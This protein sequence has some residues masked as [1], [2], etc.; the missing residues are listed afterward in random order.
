MRQTLH[1]DYCERAH[2]VTPQTKQQ[3]GSSQNGSRGRAETKLG[4]GRSFQAL[5]RLKTEDETGRSKR[6]SQ[7]IFRISRRCTAE[8]KQNRTALLK[9][10]SRQDIG[11][12]APHTRALDR[13]RLEPG[14]NVWRVEAA[15]RAAVLVDGAAYFGAL[16]EAMLQARDTIHIVGWDLDSQMR[17]VGATGSAEDGLPETL[18]AFLTALVKRNPRLRVRLLLW[19][20]SVV[21]S[22][23]RELAPIYSLFWKTPPQIDLCLDDVLPIGASHHQKLVVIDDQLAFCGGLDLT[24]RRWDTPEHRTDNPLRTDPRGVRYPPFHDVQMVVDGNA[25]TALGD[26]VRE[27]WARAA[28][29][30]IPPRRL[31]PDH[32]PWPSSV[33]PLMRD[34]EVGIARTQP[35][36]GQEPEVREVEALYAD[37][38]SAA[39]RSLYIENQFLTC[40]RTA[41]RL[42]AQLAEHPGLEAVIVV[43]K[44]YASWIE[45][46]SMLGG[47]MRFM[48]ILRRAGVGDQVRL[49][50]PEVEADGDAT[51]IMV[52]SKL[53][54]VDDRILRVGSSNLCN[55][56]MGLDT[57]CDLVVV[58]QGPEDD[59]TRAAI[60]TI[61]DRLLAEHA[62]AEAAELGA[63]IAETGSLF[64]GLDAQPL[65]H[66]RL[67]PVADTP[68]DIDVA[69]DTIA[70]P[71]EPLYD[72][73]AAPT[74]HSW[75][76][77][78]PTAL[79]I[80]AVLAAV[81]LLL[82]AW[83]YSPF[84]EP[85]RLAQALQSIAERPW[86]PAVVIVTFVL[87]GFVAF[88]VTVLMLA[89]MAVFTGWQGALLAGVGAMTSAVAT[90]FVGRLVGA[91]KLRRYMGPRINRIRRHLV[92]HGILTIATIR[93]VPIAPFTLVNLVAGAVEV[94]IFDYVAGTLLG[95]LP[96]LVVMSALGHQLVALISNPSAADAAM[97]AGFFLLWLLLSLCLQF[98]VSRH[99]EPAR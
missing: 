6:R 10:P 30:N 38:I 42:A 62:G 41:E 27:R 70:D 4:L 82:L 28:C 11:D 51:Q 47:R 36:F 81:L 69:F 84:A 16:R 63:A 80:G 68:S 40:E 45:Q 75:R 85:A 58:A 92:N 73:D 72:N 32:R 31:D 89:T 33:E 23:E 13:T 9:H 88:P 83:R 20:Y 7:S 18:V 98:F 54:I 39:E 25:A 43:P 26:L 17:L 64:A 91:S 37:M 50:Y 60:R 61:R 65:G 57:E 52:H 15:A 71:I 21:F 14:R 74:G 90:Y 12:G 93:M 5:E 1:A 99:R 35:R 95:L 76:R 67:V 87:A 56:S 78:L 59:A 96:G 86:G 66:R 29:E 53:M 3:L 94:R 48:E 79:K 49:L 22:F 8:T 2:A 34:V 77:M 97:L 44:A 19:D 55:R 24:R 46:Q